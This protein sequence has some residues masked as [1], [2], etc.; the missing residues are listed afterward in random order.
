M[1]TCTLTC[2]SDQLPVPRKATAL[3]WDCDYKKPLVFISSSGPIHTP[4]Q[5]WNWYSSSDLHRSSGRSLPVLHYTSVFPL[6]QLTRLTRNVTDRREKL[7]TWHILFG[8][9]TSRGSSVARTYEEKICDLVK[10]ILVSWVF[11]WMSKI[12]TD[13]I[14]SLSILSTTANSSWNKLFAWKQM[15]KKKKKK[16]KAILLAGETWEKSFINLTANIPSA[17]AAPLSLVLLIVSLTDDKT[18]RFL[19]GTVK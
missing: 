15:E 12:L 17:S 18:L 1:S 3:L 5:P 13:P 8:L 16:K 11:V 4:N 19:L 14:T 6:T 7:D 2:S 10:I 9:E